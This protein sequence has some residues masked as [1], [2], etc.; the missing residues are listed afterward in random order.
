[1]EQKTQ[2]IGL[3]NLPALLAVGTVAYMIARQGN[4]LAGMTGSVFLGIGFLVAGVSWFQARL[5]ERERLE[6]L[7]FDELTKSAA[8]SA[9]FNRQRNRGLSRSTLPRAI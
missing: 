4:T 6:K 2:R 1:M 5:E 8:S 3:I 9:L 7:E